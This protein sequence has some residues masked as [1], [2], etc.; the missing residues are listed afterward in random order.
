MH[1]SCLSR[2]HH[3][4]AEGTE[5]H[6]ARGG[7]VGGAFQDDTEEAAGADEEH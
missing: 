4:K 3:K 1:L 7:Q 5:T 2:R 6:T